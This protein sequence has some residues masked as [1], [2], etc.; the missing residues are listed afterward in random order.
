[1]PEITSAADIPQALTQL[2]G[3]VAAGELTPQEAAE[4]STVL[5]SLRQSFETDQLVAEVERLKTQIAALMP[6]VVG[7]RWAA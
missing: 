1:M 3:L 6:E 4:V 5:D 7:P 2:V